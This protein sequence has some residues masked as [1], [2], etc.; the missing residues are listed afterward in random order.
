MDR[1][2]VTEKEMDDKD[3]KYRRRKS[4]S[5]NIASGSSVRLLN[6][7]IDGGSFCANGRRFF[8]R[9]SFIN[10]NFFL[11]PDA[12]L[13]LGWAQSK[14]N[15]ACPIFACP[16]LPSRPRPNFPTHPYSK[17][18]KIQ[19]ICS[20]CWVLA[21]W[22]KSFLFLLTFTIDPIHHP[23]ERKSRPRRAALQSQKF[24]WFRNGKCLSESF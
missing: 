13:S 20:L 9:I 18:R 1:G 16:L 15:D 17:R 21:K 8:C 10:L 3:A 6:F 2:N 12:R 5:R 23:R 24:N 11:S 7:G 22:P 14:F 19:H 4:S